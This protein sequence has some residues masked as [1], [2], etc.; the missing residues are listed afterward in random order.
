MFI[1]HLKPQNSPCGSAGTPWTKR[2]R[3]AYIGGTAQR[4]FDAMAKQGYQPI[5]NPPAKTD[6]LN[7]LAPRVG[8]EPTT[9]RLTAAGSTIELP[10]NRVLQKQRKL[11]YKPCRRGQQ[12]FEKNRM[13]RPC[14]RILRALTIQNRAEEF[15]LWLIK[16]KVNRLSSLHLTLRPRWRRTPSS[17]NNW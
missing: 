17:S 10:R 6:G 7:N 9:T 5:K 3:R 4:N 1:G 13:L 12:L 8:L 2:C 14:A 15:C 16:H 11:L